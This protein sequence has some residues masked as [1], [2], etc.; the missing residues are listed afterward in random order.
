[1]CACAYALSVGSHTLWPCGLWLARLLSP[2]DFPGKNTGGGCHFL[3]QGIF[4]TQDL[5]WVSCVSCIGRQILYHC[6]TQKA[7]R[8]VCYILKE[9]EAWLGVL[10]L[11]RGKLLK[12][13]GIVSIISALPLLLAIYESRLALN[14]PLLKTEVSL[15]VHPKI[16]RSHQLWIKPNPWLCMW[17]CFI[18]SCSLCSITNWKKKSI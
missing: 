18:N 15:A 5:T 16:C 1:M 3:L 14:A 11:K 2:W 7:Q 17:G 10:G 13:H 8:C 9:E 4:P 6:T 12:N